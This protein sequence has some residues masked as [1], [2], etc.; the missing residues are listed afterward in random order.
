MKEDEGLGE[1]VEEEAAKGDSRTGAAEAR[2][3]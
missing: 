1:E 3:L 2:A